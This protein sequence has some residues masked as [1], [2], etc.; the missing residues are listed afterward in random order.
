MVLCVKSQNLKREPL[1]HTTK[2]LPW[3]SA[4]LDYPLSC[5]LWLY[6]VLSF[7]SMGSSVKEKLCLPEIWTRQTDG[8]GES[9][10][11]LQNFCLW[12]VKITWFLS[13]LNLT[14]PWL[15]RAYIWSSRAAIVFWS[16]PSIHSLLNSSLLQCNNVLQLLKSSFILLIFSRDSEIRENCQVYANFIKI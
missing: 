12:G 14:E 3:N 10:I 9:N 16:T 7:I 11:P 4:D 5:F 8:W 2:Y 13:K 6:T 1:L 15:T